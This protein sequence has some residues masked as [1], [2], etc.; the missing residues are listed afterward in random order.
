[1]IKLEQMAKAQA[2]A[3]IKALELLE[4]EGLGDSD[5]RE[6]KR[7]LNGWIDHITPLKAGN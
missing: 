7:E 3:L 1:M 6:L 2:K 4:I 5:L